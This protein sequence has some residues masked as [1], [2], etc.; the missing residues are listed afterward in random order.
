MTKAKAFYL[1]FQVGILTAR[2]FIFINFSRTRAHA[3]FKLIVVFTHFTPIIGDLLQ[4]IKVKASITLG[5]RKCCSKRVQPWLTGQTCNTIEGHVNDINTGLCSHQ[6]SSNAVA[7]GV[8]GV[9]MNWNAQFRLQ[10]TNQFRCS[11]RFQKTTHILNA[12]H[13]AA[14]AFQFFCLADIVI[15]IIF[16]TRLVSD[17]TSVADAAFNKFVGLEGFI[18]RNFHR[19]NP[20]ERVKDTEYINAALCRFLDKFTNQIVRIVLIANSICPTQKHL[21]ENVWNQFTQFIETCP[22]GFF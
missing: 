5:Q 22:W 10:R 18:N 2:N 11:H 16:L 13:V 14:E 12:E 4:F 6:Q 7:G 1:W 17:I 3:R 9:E 20:V 8:M 21:E 19:F 15:K